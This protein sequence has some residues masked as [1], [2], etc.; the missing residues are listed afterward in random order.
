MSILKRSIMTRYLIEIE[1]RGNQFP[2]AI[3]IIEEEIYKRDIGGE[4]ENNPHIKIVDEYPIEL[5]IRL[6]VSLGSPVKVGPESIIFTVPKHLEKCV[7][8]M[9]ENLI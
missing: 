1:E 3:G 7:E 8:R 6:R 5:D 4:I 2:S 9:F